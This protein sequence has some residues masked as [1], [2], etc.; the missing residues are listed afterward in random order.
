MNII[1]NFDTRVDVDGGINESDQGPNIQGA[2][3]VAPDVQ[4]AMNNGE[5]KGVN[6]RSHDTMIVPRHKVH[7][8]RTENIGTAANAANLS[9]LLSVTPTVRIRTI[10]DV[11]VPA[12]QSSSSISVAQATTATARVIHLV[13]PTVVDALHPVAL[14]TPVTPA[15]PRMPTTSIR[16]AIAPS[17]YLTEPEHPFSPLGRQSLRYDV[18]R[19]EV[20]SQDDF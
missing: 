9:A 1:R 7:S 13:D 3:T 5:Q 4:T 16:S 12:S 20:P 17:A 14:V 8:S 19:S 6:K 18:G 15:F 2:S 11:A 10:Q